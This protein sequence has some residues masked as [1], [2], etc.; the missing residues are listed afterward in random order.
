M[1]KLLASVLCFI[2]IFSLA[3]CTTAPTPGSEQE[4]SKTKAE[5]MAEDKPD[6]W[7]SDEK[8]TLSVF[9]RE[10]P[11]NVLNIGEVIPEGE[12]VLWKELEKMTNIRLDFDIIPEAAWNEKKNLA[13]ASGDLRDLFLQ[14]NSLTY[15]EVDKYGAQGYLTDLTPYISQEDTPFMLKAFDNYHMLRESSTS[16]DGKIYGLLRVQRTAIMGSFKPVVNT[17]WLE[18][19]NLDNPE[20]TDELYHVLKSFKENDP[21]GDGQTIPFLERDFSLIDGFLLP[22]F[23]ELPFLISI[24]DNKTVTYAN[25]EA[26]K[27]YLTYLNRLYTEKLLDNNFLSHSNDEYI[28]KTQNMQAGVIG[29]IRSAD[30]NQYE[31][32]NPLTSEYCD[33]PFTAIQDIRYFE[34]SFIITS[35]NKYPLESMKWAD[36]FFREMDEDLNG[37]TGA[38]F[39][40]GRKGFEW[41]I[42]NEDGED[43]LN[44]I[45]EPYVKDG[46]TEDTIATLRRLYVPSWGHGIQNIP[47]NPVDGYMKWVAEGNRTKLF[48]VV[49][50]DK[51]FPGAARFL[52]E[53]SLR[54]G[55]LNADITSYV[56]QMKAK[57]V[58]GEESFNNWDSYINELNKMGIEELL[59]IYQ[60]ALDRFIR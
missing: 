53:E 10:N 15:Q 54:A 47:Y 37:V 30:Y 29:G 4:P 2:M 28:A 18:Q 48:P 9:Y 46:K 50:N 44:Y 19:L 8:I 16:P 38:A 17:T 20:T 24:K 36:I 7:L 23:G 56:T 32:L 22:A 35:K 21:A 11:P 25:A 59:G 52:E 12:K 27:A 6:T 1:K 3:S 49:R 34:P 41:E 42:I 13:F 14:S 45:I 39:N 5:D 58:T 31:F 40:I 26:Y 33:E 51:H 43:Y 60:N 55:I 57:F